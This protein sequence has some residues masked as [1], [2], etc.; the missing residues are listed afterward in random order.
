MRKLS[1]REFKLFVQVHTV[2]VEPGFT[3]MVLDSK[4]SAPCIFPQESE[5][6]RKEAI[7]SALHSYLDF[8]IPVS[9]L[10]L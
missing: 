1:H 9:D 5:A 6:H 2:R 10:S 3:S 4:A 8:L 7:Y